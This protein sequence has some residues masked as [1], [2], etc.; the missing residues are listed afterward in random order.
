MSATYH[1]G[2]ATAAEVTAETR[3]AADAR[4]GEVTLSQFLPNVDRD[5]LTFEFTPNTAQ[6][7]PSA[8]FRAFDTEAPLGSEV[9]SHEYMGEIPPMS[10]KMPLGEYRQLQFRQ[11]GRT[12]IR[13]ALMRKAVVNGIALANRVEVA[14]AQ[15]LTTGKFVLTKENGLSLQVDFQRKSSHTVVA[16]TAWSNPD[17]NVIG[18]LLAWQ[19]TYRQSNGGDARTMMISSQIQSWLTVNKGIIAEARPGIT[20]V[21]RVSPVEV[22]QVLASYGFTNVVINDDVTRRPNGDVVRTI[23]ENVV[24]LLPGGGGGLGGGLLGET[25][26]GVPAEAF[27]PDY[28]IGESERAGIF[29]MTMR[30]TDPEGMYVLASSIVIPV[31][32]DANATFAATV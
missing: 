11:A 25:I 26:W 1:P 30:Q 20:G 23:P 17:A 2:F 27:Q 22:L 7:I 19:W 10:Q 14:R 6:D 12:A 3:A 16:A 4:T 9:S 28:G 15:V 8:V 24:T 13:D 31:L 21:T 5:T 32:N 29:G 18:D